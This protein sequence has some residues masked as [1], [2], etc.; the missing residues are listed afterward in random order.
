MPISMNSLPSTGRLNETLDTNPW[1]RLR[2]K[3]ND[4]VLTLI[5]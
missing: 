2:F 4:L 1:V 5:F 3:Y